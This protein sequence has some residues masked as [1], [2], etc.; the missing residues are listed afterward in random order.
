V[1]LLF[2]QQKILIER[3]R[4]QRF[5]SH[6]A[7]VRAFADLRAHAQ[8]MARQGETLQLPDPFEAGAGEKVISLL[9][10]LEARENQ[11]RSKAEVDLNI[12]SLQAETNRR[13]VSYNEHHAWLLQFREKNRGEWPL[14]VEFL[15]LSAEDLNDPVPAADSE[16]RN[17][18]RFPDWQARAERL[19]QAVHKLQGMTA[20][21][22]AKIPGEVEI[23][24]LKET[25]RAH[26]C[27]ISTLFDAVRR[28]A[29]KVEALE[30]RLPSQAEIREAADAVA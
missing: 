1:S 11:A 24:R 28:L 3:L 27:D 6:D 5:I 20:E 19:R 10:A 21:E 7:D 18:G 26:D 22:R 4:R 17:F 29:Q 2:G 12:A 25:L 13:W 15:G 16:H 9:E 14:L 30:S 8:S 23:R